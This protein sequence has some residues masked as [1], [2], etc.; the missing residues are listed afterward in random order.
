MLANNHN[1]SGMQNNRNLLKT[2]WKAS[3]SCHDTNPVSLNKNFKID[4]LKV[5]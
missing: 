1:I 4:V 5:F 2:V 3:P